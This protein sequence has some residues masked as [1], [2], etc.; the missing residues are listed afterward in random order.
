[1]S[2][3]GHGIPDSAALAAHQVVGH[4]DQEQHQ[5]D[6][7]RKRSGLSDEAVDGEGVFIKGVERRASVSVTSRTMFHE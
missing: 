4:A 3:D 2:S 5:N 1:M 6:L 7:E